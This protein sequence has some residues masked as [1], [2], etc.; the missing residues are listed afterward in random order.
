MKRIAQLVK[1]ESTLSV[2]T[3]SFDGSPQNTPLFYLSDDTLQLY[4]FSSPSS[5]HSGNLKTNPAAAV[6]I[7]RST[8][9]W[10]KI[11]GVQMCGTVSMITD[12]LRFKSISRE[13]TERFHLGTA[14]RAVMSRSGLFLFRPSWV[15]Y[16]DHGKRPFHRFET[17]LVTPGA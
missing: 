11:R 8:D 2:A 3:C 13:Y 12:P 14:L 17:T 1:R 16:I 6:T 4:W 15:R 5:E 10:K 9:Q 7:Y